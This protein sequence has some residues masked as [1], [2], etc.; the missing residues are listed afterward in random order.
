MALFR[1]KIFLLKMNLKKA[2]ENN[3]LE[4][5]IKEREKEK[6]DQKAFDSTLSSMVGNLKVTQETSKTQPS[7]DCNDTQTH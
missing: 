6:G 1:S 7:S 4:S 2:I 5:F 3:N